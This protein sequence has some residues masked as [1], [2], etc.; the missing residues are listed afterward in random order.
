MQEWLDLGGGWL[1]FLHLKKLEKR[2][3]NHQNPTVGCWDTTFCPPLPQFWC[4]SIGFDPEPPKKPLFLILVTFLT[5]TGFWWPFDTFVMKCWQNQSPFWAPSACMQHILVTTLRAKTD[6]LGWNLRFE[7]W[8]QKSRSFQ[9]TARELK[10]G[11]AIG[12]S[13]SDAV[14]KFEPNPFMDSIF[15][16]FWSWARNI[17]WHASETLVKRWEKWPGKGQIMSS[18]VIRGHQSPWGSSWR[19]EEIIWSEIHKF[20]GNCKR[21]MLCYSTYRDSTVAKS[22][23]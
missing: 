6:G 23:A 16:G 4:L 19:A 7:I 13:E 11:M 18:E 8:H 20:E 21:A 9:S 17:F 14:S 12:M 5:K 3:K 22:F 10:F 15:T 2:W 1:Q